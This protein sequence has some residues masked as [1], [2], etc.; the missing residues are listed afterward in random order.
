MKAVLSPLLRGVH[1]TVV[2]KSEPE[3]AEEASV[4]VPTEFT[5]R[6]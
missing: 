2:P 4:Q 5:N 6:Q 1:T 3:Q